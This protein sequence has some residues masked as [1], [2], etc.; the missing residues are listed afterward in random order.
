MNRHG[1]HLPED[2]KHTFILKQN[3]I[4]YFYG[5]GQPV[6][7]RHVIGQSTKCHTDFSV[8]NK[9]PAAL[10]ATAAASLTF[11]AMVTV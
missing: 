5:A 8:S 4:T 10:A 3:F 6:S 2:N 11:L 9:M 7:K 1:Y